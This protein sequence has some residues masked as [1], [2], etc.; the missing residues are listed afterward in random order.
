MNFAYVLLCGD[1]VVM[2]R[3]TLQGAY[4]SYQALFNAG[5]DLI[6]LTA[7]E[8]DMTANLNQ[9]GVSYM[10]ICKPTMKMITI[11]RTPLI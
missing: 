11:H 9:H 8:A 4:E 2:S 7:T 6:V 5:P 10:S 1:S 3:T